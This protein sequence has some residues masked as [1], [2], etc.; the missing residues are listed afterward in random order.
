MQEI[1]LV[2]PGPFLR[3]LQEDKSGRLIKGYDC[4]QD[5]ATMRIQ[6]YKCPREITVTQGY[7]IQFATDLRNIEEDEYSYLFLRAFD[8]KTHCILRSRCDMSNCGLDGVVPNEAA[9]ET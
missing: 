7:V 5:K 2:L 4:F 9:R 1:D 6:L 3:F 8:R